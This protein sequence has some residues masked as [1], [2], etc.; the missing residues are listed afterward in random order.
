MYQPK[1]SARSLQQLLTGDFAFEATSITHDMTLHRIEVIG[2]FLRNKSAPID[3]PSEHRA[4]SQTELFPE[5]IGDRRL[6]LRTDNGFALHL[7][8]ILVEIWLL[9]MIER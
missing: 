3:G 6:S 8:G 4:R 9:T 2:P 7:G 5:E 1:S